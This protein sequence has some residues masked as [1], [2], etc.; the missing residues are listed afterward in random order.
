LDEIARNY[1]EIVLKGVLSGI[2]QEPEKGTF[3]ENSTRRM[4]VTPKI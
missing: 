1:S 2:A 3:P 4:G